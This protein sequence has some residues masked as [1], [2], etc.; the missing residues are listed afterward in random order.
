MN[1]KKAVGYIRVSTSAQAEDDKFG[2]SSQEETI[3]K[4]CAENGYELVRL[5]VDEGISGV[6]DSR[7]ELDKILYG[8][9]EVDYD[10]V[11]V[12]K[13]DRVARDIK[14]YFYYLYTLEKKNIK[15]V[16]V[17]EDFDDEMGLG[18]VY[19]SILLFVAEQERKN[20]NM[21]TSSGRNIKARG[22]GYA[23]GNIPYG[24]ENVDGK[25]EIKASEKEIVEIVFY[26]LDIGTSYQKI[27]D[28]LTSKG[29]KTRSG[30]EFTTS[31]IQ[32]IKKNKEVYLGY[33]KYGDNNYVKGVH[34]ALI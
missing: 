5:Y 21:R 16:S 12:A 1:T 25:L 7:P 20:I 9:D 11:V 2:I 13:S 29:Y 33:Y 22:G 27:A 32:S 17:S 10:T 15:L 3:K 30:G 8:T 6:K 23:G 18:N 34:S 14:L 31:Q 28:K 19:R 26:E 4:Y 24:Y